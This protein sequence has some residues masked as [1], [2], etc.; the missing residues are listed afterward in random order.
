MKVF[1]YYGL[2]YVSVDIMFDLVFEVV[3][4]II[5]CVIVIVICGF[6]L[7]LYCGKIFGMYYG[8][9]FGYEFMG[10]VV[11]VGFEVIVVCKGDWVV[12]LFVIVCGDCFFCCLQ[13]YVVC[14]SINSGQ[15]VMFN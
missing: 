7:Y 2:Y 11:E 1:I 15:G 4:D 9:I 6:D 12:I 10:E 8:D 3:D 13:Q 14:E 5:L